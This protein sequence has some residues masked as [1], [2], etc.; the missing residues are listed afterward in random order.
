MN[1]VVRPASLCFAPMQHQDIQAVMR[2]ERACYSHPWSETIFHDCLRAGYQGTLVR[3]DETLAAYA[4][5][6][7]AAGEAHLLNLCVAQQYRRQGIGA[8][9]LAYQLRKAQAARAETVYL[10][11][12]AS[13]QAAQ[14]L[15]QA[16]G[17][18][19]IGFRP[20]YYPGHGA[21]EDAL[22]FAKT[23]LSDWQEPSQR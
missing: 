20:H 6:T 2:I 7:V 8:E 11:V 3:F 19:E 13:N 12:R 23:L 1:A 14:A 10:E 16:F 17:F 15:Y 4:M 9:L 21:R 22:V 18:N 5:L